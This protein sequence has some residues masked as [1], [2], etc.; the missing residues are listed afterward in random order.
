MDFP[1]PC[2]FSGEYLDQPD[3]ANLDVKPSRVFWPVPEVSS[4]C[5]TALTQ[6]GVG[7][8]WPVSFKIS[9]MK[10]WNCPNSPMHLG[11]H[12]SF[13]NMLGMEE[14]FLNTRHDLKSEWWDFSKCFLSGEW[15]IPTKYEEVL[16]VQTVFPRC[17]LSRKV[18]P[19]H[20]IDTTL[21]EGSPQKHCSKFSPNDERIHQKY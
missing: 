13:W 17:E 5:T 15:E 9:I 18:S 19:P 8:G 2:Y 7:I 4:L 20:Q 3:P 1:L 16:R 12:W 10:R 21:E 6:S 14:R 11:K